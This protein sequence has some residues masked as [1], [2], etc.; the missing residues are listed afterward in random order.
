MITTA[1][2]G[3][4]AILAGNI[5]AI[6]AHVHTVGSI[7][8]I[9]A[10][11]FLG[12]C[13][14]LAV[15]PSA[16]HVEDETIAANVG[17]TDA[18]SLSAATAALLGTQLT[19]DQ[20]ALITG[21]T[22]V[23]T[24]DLIPALLAVLSIHETRLLTLLAV[25]GLAGL[26]ADRDA[27]RAEVLGTACTLDEAL[28]VLRLVAALA[29]GVAAWAVV[30]VTILQTA[31]EAGVIAT[32]LAVY[33]ALL[34]GVLAAGTAGLLLITRDDAIAVMAG[35]TIPQ[36]D[37]L[38]RTRRV[39]GLQGGEDQLEGIRQATGLEG[40]RDRYSG[41]AGAKLAFMAD[42]RVVGPTISLARIRGYRI[43]LE[44]V[45]RQSVE[46]HFAAPQ[47]QLELAEVNRTLGVRYIEND[48][49][50][51]NHHYLG[52]GI[53]GE[54]AKHGDSGFQLLQYLILGNLRTAVLA[55]RPGGGDEHTL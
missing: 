14:A 47:D 50:L 10:T 24:D 27:F 17:M 35:L 46:A 13:T 2:A 1:G 33:A 49:V 25:L 12:S 42:M 20:G 39:I 43:D 7:F 51:G 19:L 5:P 28:G 6:F 30:L 21:T 8:F 52:A 54:A 15:H 38:V 18:A 16:L 26:A 23:R 32:C 37:L 48:V 11:A 9:A 36:L 3:A 53:E 4:P 41:F 34:A 22:A 45:G 55:V 31:R 44:Q 29:L 40:G